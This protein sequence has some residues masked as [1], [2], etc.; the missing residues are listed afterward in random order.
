MTRGKASAALD[1]R[2]DELVKFYG[3]TNEIE[4]DDEDAP[5]GKRRVVTSQVIE[6]EVERER[7][8]DVVQAK[9]DSPEFKDHLEGYKRLLKVHADNTATLTAPFTV[10]RNL[11]DQGKVD[12]MRR[13]LLTVVIEPL[14]ALDRKARLLRGGPKGGVDQMALGAP[15]RRSSQTE[16]IDTAT[17]WGLSIIGFCLMIGFFPRL[18]AL[19]GAAILGMFYMAWPPFPGIP[20]PPVSTGH[21]L[22]V[23][24][25]LIE[26][27]AVLVLATVP[28]GRWAGLSSFVQYFVLDPL[29]PPAAP[30]PVA[31]QPAIAQRPLSESGATQTG[32]GT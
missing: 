16:L 32:A 1:D 21:Y 8:R 10:E 24:P 13:E 15:P 25:L 29:R 4:V 5:G 27:F 30:A 12:A 17:K 9:L 26:F 6:L 20:D 31:T 22:I 23:N 7:L 28:T 2:F 11:A 3:F 18:A 19:G 14:T